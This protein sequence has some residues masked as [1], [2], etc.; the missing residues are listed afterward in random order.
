MWRER[1]KWSTSRSQCLD[2]SWECLISTERFKKC[3]FFSPKRN[4]WTLT[5]NFFIKK[6]MWFRCLTTKCSPAVQARCNHNVSTSYV[7]CVDSMVLRVKSHLSD[8]Q[9]HDKN[10]SKL[11]PGWIF[12]ILGLK[13]IPTMIHSREFTC[14]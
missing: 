14:Y 7:F 5:V 2:K 3:T 10:N 1:K 4:S 13:F 12:V 9:W 11:I 6:P 8:G